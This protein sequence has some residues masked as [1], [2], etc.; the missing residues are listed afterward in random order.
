MTE[1]LHDD[2]RTINLDVVR[3]LVT[4]DLPERLPV[5]LADHAGAVRQPPGHGSPGARGGRLTPATPVAG[6]IDV[7]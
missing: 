5:L 6:T 3:T 1:H 2:E 4:R 7:R